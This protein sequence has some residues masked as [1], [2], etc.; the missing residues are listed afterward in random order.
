MNV[1][2]ERI[3][4][5]KA[6]NMLK[7]NTHN[8][9]A[10]PTYVARLAG[11]MERGEWVQNGESIKLN[12]D[13]LLDGQHRLLAIV[14]SGTTQPMLVVRDLPTGAQETLDIGARRNLADILRLRGEV[15]VNTL[16]ATLNHV[17]RYRSFRTLRRAPGKEPTPAQALALL[18]AEPGIRDCLPWGRMV[19]KAGLGIAPSL[20]TTIYYLIAE[21]DSEEAGT[22]F[23]RLTS[24]DLLESTDPIYVLRRLLIRQRT[25][26]SERKPGYHLAALTIK[27]FNAW[28]Q[29]DKV[30]ALYWRPGG[31]AKEAF[32]EIELGNQ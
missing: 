26:R 14:E 11:A 13:V 25:Q 7:L 3:G 4:P 12:G 23:T 32:P 29:G 22:F 18:E 10:R 15:D 24:G 27:A 19:N 9:N 21:K 8:R 1:Q 5:R 16:A 31:K 28:Q 2:V 20:T 6:K 30:E 17:W